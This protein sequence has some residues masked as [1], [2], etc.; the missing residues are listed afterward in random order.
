MSSFMILLINGV[1]HKVVEGMAHLERHHAID[2]MHASISY[3]A[4]FGQFINTGLVYLLVNANLQGNA[5]FE[6]YNNGAKESSSSVLNNLSGYSDFTPTWYAEVGNAITLTMFMLAFTPHMFPLITCLRFHIR[7]NCMCCLSSAATQSELNQ[8]FHPPQFHYMTRYSQLS[9]TI[10]ICMMYS[11][12]IPFLY[13]I[14]CLTCFLFYWVDK[15]MFCWL[16]A[17]PPQYDP[18]INQT[19]SQVLG[20]ALMIHV[21]FGTWMLGN[22]SILVSNVGNNTQY[23]VQ[24]L[25]D[26]TLALR[27]DIAES[28]LSYIGADDI[29]HHL[30]QVHVLP[31]FALM[32]FLILGVL[33]N[34]SWSILGSK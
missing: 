21:A 27:S 6:N 28:A 16:Y 24:T 23:V 32:I 15:A 33:A 34:M 20:Y 9:V 4:M 31:L 12:G 14:G 26:G 3:R 10:L 7:V 30:L 13:V 8:K 1:Y 5:F 19:Y 22:K 11:T 18:K 25:N 2:S 29:G 17:K